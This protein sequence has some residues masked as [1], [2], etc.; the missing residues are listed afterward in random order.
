M[1]TKGKLLTVLLFYCFSLTV[2]AQETNWQDLVNRK[3]YASVI[4]Y[5]DSLTLADS[6]S[7]M[8]MNSFGQAYEG[9]LRHREAYACYRLCLAMDTANV[10]MLNTLARTA[11]NLGKASEAEGYFRRVLDSDSLNFYANYQLARLYYQLGE[12]AKAIGQYEKLQGQ[13]PDN[14]TLWS[15]IGDCYSRLE[16]YPGAVLAYF[17]AYNR[18]RENAS[19]A[20]VLINTMYRL[21]HDYTVEGLAICDTALRYN[22]DSRLLLRSKAMGLYMLKE[23][24]RADSVYSSLLAA[25]D[26]SYL[27]LKYGGASKYYAGFFLPSIEPLEKAYEQDTTSVDVCL[28][29]G[30]AL[31]KT[32]DRKQAHLLLDKAE[33]GLKPIPFLWNQLLMFRAETYSREGRKKEAASLYYQAWLDTPMRLEP[34]REIARLYTVVD[35][36]KYPNQ[37]E[38]Q[39]GLFIHTLYMEE[40][41]KKGADMEMQLFSRSLLHSFY[42]DLFFRGLSEETMIAPDGKRTK[43]SVVDLRSLINKLPDESAHTLEMRA[44]GEGRSAEAARLFY[45]AWKLQDMRVELAREVSFL[46][47]RMD[48]SDCKTEEELQRAV[49]AYVFYIRELLKSKRSL[50][51]LDTAHWFLRSLSD[52]L[53]RR[54]ISRQS[55]LA[56]DGQMSELSTAELKSLLAQLPEISAA[57]REMMEQMMIAK[58]ERKG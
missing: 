50:V 44:K 28:L 13:D 19:L 48:I 34:L 53:S 38:Y 4:A 17:Q 25:G 1:G 18:N 45:Q 58:K 6:S 11:T 51:N 33:Q 22:P 27:T 5:A 20:S 29:L 10:D 56:P 43:I 37:E 36:S 7:Y 54:G 30:S 42:E 55:M 46:C 49:F 26:S 40:M 21:G 41:L 39:R 12:Y 24:T 23:F 47:G 2:N 9:M 15:H 14:P 8:V 31:G 16:L 35:V 32:Y 57:T 3:Q 52:D